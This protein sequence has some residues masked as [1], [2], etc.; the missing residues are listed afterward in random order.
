MTLF[1]YSFPD[2]IAEYF[3]YDS[4]KN[5]IEIGF[6]SYS[7][8]GDVIE[9]PCKLVVKDWSKANSKLHN[10]K[11]YE[12]LESRLGVISLILSIT[13]DTNRVCI[14][15]NTIDDRYIDLLFTNPEIYVETSS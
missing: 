7:R 11:V 3:L 1:E 10:T 14:V 15:A 2:E 9:T 5:L 4:K 13:L 8:G 12:P 6:E